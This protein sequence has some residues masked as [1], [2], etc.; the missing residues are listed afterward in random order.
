MFLVKIL[1]P[2]LVVFVAIPLAIKFVSADLTT[3]HA[4]THLV[5][6]AVAIVFF[7]GLLLW[8]RFGW[9]AA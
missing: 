4:F 8:R 3:A 5:E 6:V 9:R 1:V 7:G 2:V